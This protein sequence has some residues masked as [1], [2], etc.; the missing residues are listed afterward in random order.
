MYRHHEKAK[1]RTAL[2]GAAVLC[3]SQVLAFVLPGG[4]QTPV[5]LS[6]ADG[7]FLPLYG[8]T[9][10]VGI[11]LCLAYLRSG[12]LVTPMAFIVGLCVAWGAVWGFAWVIEPH[13]L[14]WRTAL[15]Y[16]TFGV[17]VAGLVG[18]TPAIPRNKGAGAP[19]DGGQ[20]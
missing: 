11:L 17:V 18:L 10:F 4:A 1:R 20:R 19:S 7:V 16:W 2:S 8:L 5:K 14:W 6:S 3:G 13:T 9:W 15:V 12:R